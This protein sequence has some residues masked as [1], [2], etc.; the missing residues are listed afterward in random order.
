MLP[1]SSA[2]SVRRGRANLMRLLRLLRLKVRLHGAGDHL[3]D[4]LGNRLHHL[5]GN[6]RVSGWLNGPRSISS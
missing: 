6:F 3:P 2:Q 4:M 1:L 5:V